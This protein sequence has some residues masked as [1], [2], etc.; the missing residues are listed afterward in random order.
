[1]LL[2]AEKLLDNNIWCLTVEARMWSCRPLLTLPSLKVLRQADLNAIGACTDTG[3]SCSWLLQE[4]EA[5]ASSNQGYY[6]DSDTFLC[7]NDQRLR[8]VKENVQ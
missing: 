3:F 8:R 4:E 6:R 5:R 7:H 2:C 1:M